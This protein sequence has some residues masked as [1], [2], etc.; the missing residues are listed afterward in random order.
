MTGLRIS[1]SDALPLDAAEVLLTL[2]CPVPAH[3]A[4][5]LDAAAA[6]IAR[7][8]ALAEPKTLWRLFPLSWEDGHPSLV[9]AALPLPGS[10]IAG[11]LAGS[12]YCLVTA[13]TLGLATERELLRLST[14]PAEALYFDAACSLMIEA[15]ADEAE[16]AILPTLPAHDDPTFRYAPGYGDLPLSI[17]APLL[18]VLDAPRKIGLTL[19]ATGMMLPRKSITGFVGIRV[20]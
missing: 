10:D 2:G 5:L 15:A 3:T 4:E 11:H 18:A 1:P 13:S 16:A 8:R 14:L 19:T 17:Q 20:R 6:G 7:A 12:T 9:G